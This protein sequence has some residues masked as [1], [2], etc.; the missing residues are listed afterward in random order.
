MVGWPY[1]NIKGT[2]IIGIGVLYVDFVSVDD[3]LELLSDIFEIPNFQWLG[4]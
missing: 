3:L 1:I 2:A 4:F